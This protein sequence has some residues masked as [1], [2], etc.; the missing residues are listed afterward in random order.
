MSE[1]VYLNGRIVP[2]EEAKISVTD[3]GLLHGASTFTT[4]LAHNGRVFRLDRHLHRLMDAVEFYGL[5]TDATPE[6]LESATYRL[7]E[8]DELSDAR[9]RITLTAG[10]V[11]GGGPTT[12]ITAQPLPAYPEEWY[13]KGISVVVA[14]FKQSRGDPIVGRKTGCYFSR[15]LARQEAAAKN[16]EE[17][18]WYTSENYLAE[19][20]FCNVFLILGGKVLTPARDTPVLA[21][22]AREAVIELCGELGVA[23]DS[24]TPLTV[25]EML[26]AEEMFLTGS[27]TGIRPVVRVERHAVGDERPGPVTQELMAAYRQLLE[28][29]CP[30]RAS[31]AAE[32]AS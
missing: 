14:S 5:A 10:D 6:G 4:M 12:I 11:R 29:E 3:V 19:A 30:P 1:H 25:K 8:T 18:L 20:C 24:E 23:C 28:R 9:V 15:I 32:D 27:T 22:I 7:M 16:A 2:A 13:T 26:A 17:A 31:A 21:G